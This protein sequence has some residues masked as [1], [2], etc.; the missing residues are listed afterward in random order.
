MFNTF[1]HF[2]FFA[3]QHT[4]PCIVIKPCTVNAV[5]GCPRLDFV[6]FMQGMFL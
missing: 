3:Y 2:S 1:F 6:L 4:G 5:L